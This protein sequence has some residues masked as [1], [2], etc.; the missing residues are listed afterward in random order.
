MIQISIIPA[1]QMETILTIIN[2][3]NLDVLVKTVSM[4]TEIILEIIQQIV[5]ITIVM[6]NFG[7][8]NKF[9]LINTVPQEFVML[10]KE[11]NLKIW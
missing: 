10:L 8:V 7:I 6:L 1:M 9:V 2:L 11:P 3:Q 5:I 4:L